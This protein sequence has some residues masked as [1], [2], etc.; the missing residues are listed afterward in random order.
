MIMPAK[1]SFR[2][3]RPVATRP[4]RSGQSQHSPWGWAATGVLLGLLVSTLAFAPANWLAG[5]LRQASGGRLLLEDARGTL[6]RGAARLTL[7][8]GIGSLDAAS[9]PGRVHWQLRPSLTAGGAG[10][11]LALQADCCLPQAWVWRVLPRWNGLQ[12]AVSDHQ[13]QWPAQWLAGLGT[14]WN[15]LQLQGQL[16][17]GTQALSLSWASGRLQVTGAAQLEAQHLS[18]RLSTLQPM[19][20]YRLAL[21]GGQHP[22][23]LLSTLSGSLQLSG[24]GEWVGGKLRFVGEA[25]SA[26]ESQA[27]LSNLL[28]I[29]GRRS[30]ARSIINVG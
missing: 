24:R 23:L 28:N 18:S 20:S 3:A 26:P 25:S 4:G 6:W 7:T 8:G 1:P 22:E 27:A 12:I 9:L 14:P 16:A 11:A 21:S 19:G 2:L 10:L 13:S 5:L 17:L 15:T 30:G 29:I